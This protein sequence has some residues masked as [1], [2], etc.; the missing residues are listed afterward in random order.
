MPVAI[1]ARLGPYEIVGF[2]GAGGMGEVYRAR[3]PRLGREVAIKI[4]PAAFAG[5]ADRLRR[6]ELEAKAASLLSHPGILTVHDIGTADGAPYI[7]SELLE[8]ETLC[9]RLS[10]GPLAPRRSVEIAAAIADALAAAHTRG[11]VH[12]D[13][14]PENLFLTRDGRVKI[15]DFG[16]AKLTEAAVDLGAGTVSMLTDVGVAVGTLG[17][18]AP[19]QLRGEPTDHRADLFALGAILHEMIAGAP[20]F[21]RESRVQTVNAVLESDPPELAPETAPGIQRIVGRL[22]EKLPDARFQSAPDLAFALNTLSG[23]APAPTVRTLPRRAGVDWRLAAALGVIAAALAAGLTWTLRES[24]RPPSGPITRYSVVPTARIAVD[25]FALSPNGRLLA[26]AG[27]GQLYLRS[28]DELESRPMAGTEGAAIPFFSPDGQWIAFR[29]NGRQL[30]KVSING[31]TPISIGDVGGVMLEGHW[32]ADGRIFMSIRL[33]GLR[34]V[35][36]EGG[37]PTQLT[38]PDSAASEIDHHAP[39]ALPGGAVLFSVHTGPEL[40]RIAVRSAAGV[41]RTLIDDG[42]YARYVPSGHLV[43][44]RADGMYAAPFDVDRLSLT[45]PPVRVL[46]NVNLQP[47]NGVINFSVA[48]NGTLAFVPTIS[49]DGRQLIWVDRAGRV[50]PLQAPPQAYSY[51]SIS[52]DGLRLAVQISEGVRDHIWLYEFASGALTR[53]SAEGAD[54]RPVWMPE[55]QAVSFATRRKEVRLIVRQRLDASAPLEDLVSGRNTVWPGAWTPDGQA[56]IYVED[57]PTSLAV[58]NLLQLP[59]GRKPEPLIGPVHLQPSLSPDGKWMAYVAVEGRP[60]IFVRQLGGG[61]ARQV[62]ADGGGQPR[63]S[64]DGRELFFRRQS[65]SLR[66]PIETTPVLQVGR[67]ERLFTEELPLATL[68]VHRAT[69]S[70]PTASAS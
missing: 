53:L 9:E 31:G 45:G 66:I 37:T 18:M 3:D 55:G 51:P 12:R 50:E 35:S 43:F 7:V 58:L 39:Q 54:S 1:G 26:Y 52:P 34:T 5:D 8:G 24:P 46:E 25:S 21:K 60:Q 10:R 14:K 48:A 29:S 32:A 27:G 4:L 30:K 6:F 13:L 41:Q 47:E 63:W 70:R 57:P 68:S 49:I 36:A 15:L 19:E 38:S 11:I 65:D 56:L 69:M 23:T 40:F 61:A 62:T 28:L 42:F 33:H 20:P 2:L 17:Y 22:L 16:I 64:R 44:G 67:P 59:V